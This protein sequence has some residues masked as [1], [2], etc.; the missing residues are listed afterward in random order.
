[1]NKYTSIGGG[2]MNKV[3]SSEE[4]MKYIN[5]MDSENSVIQFSDREKG[6]LLL[7]FKRKTIKQ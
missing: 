1:M 3:M 2:K 5:N 7:F 4:L 6:G